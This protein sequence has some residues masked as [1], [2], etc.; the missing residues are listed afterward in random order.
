VIVPALVIISVS[1]MNCASITGF[2]DLTAWTW[3]SGHAGHWVEKDGL[4]DYDGK[5]TAKDPCLWTEAEFADFELQLEWRFPRAPVEME[6]P[7]FGPDGKETGRKVKV[8]DAGDSGVYLRGN[9]KSQVNI[10][11]WPCGSGEVWGYRTDPKMPDDVRAAVTP[12]ENA[13]RPPGE[14]NRFLIT[15]R[16]DRLTVVLNGRTVIENARLPGVASKGRIALQHHGDPVQ[17]RHIRIR[18]LPP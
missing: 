5:S 6:R 1:A 3:E 17:F 9:S 2:S 13:D 10:W 16:G 11:C 18:Q 8:Q 14:W 12:R 4:I 7:L 15:M